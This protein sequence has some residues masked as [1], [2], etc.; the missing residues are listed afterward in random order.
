[1]RIE[2]NLRIR[3]H[4]SEHLNAVGGTALGQLVCEDFA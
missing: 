2:I 4:A 3:Q 1:M